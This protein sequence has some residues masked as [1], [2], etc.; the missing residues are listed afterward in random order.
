MIKVKRIK[1][2]SK[3]TKNLII[4]PGGPGLSSEA[5]RDA[6]VLNSEADL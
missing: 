6:S 1:G 3:T 2:T 4:L 5:L